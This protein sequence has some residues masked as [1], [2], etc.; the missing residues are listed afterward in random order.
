MRV[1]SLCLISVLAGSPALAN[2]AA[3][4]PAASDPT[5]TPSQ[6]T[7]VI[8]Q[9]AQPQREQPSPRTVE[10][11][12]GI[13]RKL[14]WTTLAAGTLG[15]LLS[16]GVVLYA[17]LDLEQCER[18]GHACDDKKRY[19]SDAV[20]ISIAGGIGSSALL[21]VSKFLFSNSESRHMVTVYGD[22]PPEGLPYGGYVA[23]GV[24]LGAAITAHVMMAR[25][26]GELRDP[27]AH[28]TEDATEWIAAKYRYTRYA[29]G[30]LYSLTGAFAAVTLFETVRVLRADA[31]ERRTQV[32]VAP[33]ASGAVF[34]LAGS[35]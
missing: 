3:G 5:P 18:S 23:T 6:P 21:G 28:P 1:A 20:Y 33:T 19:A 35:F 4:P 29:A 13:G 34:S 9:P 22:P 31:R 26:A 11:G 27:S 2:P 32:S 12:G 15:G 17:K 10:R 16:G 7:V 14:A 8:V 30:A 24:T 25:A